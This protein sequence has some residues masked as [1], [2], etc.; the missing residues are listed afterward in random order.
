ML[1]DKDKKDKELLKKL[2]PDITAANRKMVNSMTGTTFVIMLVLAFFTFFIPHCEQA[3]ILYLSMAAV[4]AVIHLCLIAVL[5]FGIFL[6]IIQG[7]EKESSIFIVIIFA[8]PLIFTTK[9]LFTNILTVVFSIIF[10]IIDSFF[11]S[12]DIF[13][14]DIF[15]VSIFCILS[16]F[17]GTYMSWVKIS[18]F[19]LEYNNKVSAKLKLEETELEVDKKMEIL[20]SIAEIYNT[21]HVVDLKEFTFVE[22]A[23]NDYVRAY[24]TPGGKDACNQMRTAISNLVVPEDRDSAMEF[25]ELS[26]VKERMKGKKVISMDFKGIHYGWLR[27][28]FIVNQMDVDETPKQVLFSTEIID[29]DRRREEM[30]L[31]R[32]TTDE[33]TGFYNRH[34]FETDITE[35]Q[36]NR[37][38]DNLA[39]ISFDINELKIINDSVGHAAGDE[40]I[41]AAAH[42]IRSCFGEH[43]KVYRIGGDEFVSIVNASVENL[44]IL[45][46]KL[47][48]MT[49]NYKGE[50]INHVALSVGA[51]S[52]MEFTDESIIELEKIADKRMY[53]SKS[54]YYSSK[55]IDRRGQNAVLRVVSTITKKILK[56]NLTEDSYKII[57]MDEAERTEEKGFAP[58]LSTWL[59][60]FCDV[61]LVHPEDREEYLKK[62]DINYMNDYFENNAST[63]KIFYRRF[64]E[65]GFRK[66]IMELIPS[67]NYCD[68][69]KELYLFVKDIDQE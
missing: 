68:S 38:P 51:A 36:K 9:P 4:Y 63:L 65:D 22:F 52:R 3:R 48:Q 59:Y 69:N 54:K 5:V 21:L 1:K 20:L 41:K 62:T 32:S 19:K 12:P 47:M 2:L 6:S 26:T 44:N 61:G 14:A 13:T 55:G 8:V 37:L 50:Y 46:E 27:A 24:V 43:G 42:C 31:R 66:V 64:T 18:N 60:N 16:V 67:D 7:P 57:S 53:E 23:S 29:E 34:A 39:I 30:L 33:L 49:E 28:S 17:A 35:L 25:T 15:N 10:L 45:I 58:N 40:L 11:K 56:V